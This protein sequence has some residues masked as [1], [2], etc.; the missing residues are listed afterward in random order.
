ME[1]MRKRLLYVFL[2]SLCCPF[3]NEHIW[4]T[5]G[6]EFW[7]GYGIIFAIAFF[8]LTMMFVLPIKEELKKEDNIKTT[9][10]E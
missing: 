2:A 3:L 1:T 10:N 7:I 5:S 8:F 9:E 6:I 4:E